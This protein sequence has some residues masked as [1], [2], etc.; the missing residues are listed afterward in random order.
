MERIPE[1]ELM[2]AP[3]QAL[4]YAQA[5]FEEPNEQFLRLLAERFPRHA[6]HRV[7]DLGCGPADIPLRLARRR[8]AV[9]IWAVDG[10]QAMLEL[11][12]RAVAE[13]GLAARVHC[14]R[15]R[16][17]SEPPPRE[18]QAVAFDTCISNSLLHHLADPR[19]LWATVAGLRRG[20]AVAVMDLLRP[21][22]RKAARSIVET[23]A[24]GEPEVLRRDFFHS[25]CAAYRPEEVRDQLRAADLGHLQ[26]DVVSDRHLLVSGWR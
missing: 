24:G 26:V 10:A 20:T 12:R 23:Y 1:P 21:A 13:S 6:P 19:V 8:P 15:W 9:E 25:L 4:A 18:L 7:L 5:D 2:D 14:L 17:G 16:L 22:D 11:A 3:E